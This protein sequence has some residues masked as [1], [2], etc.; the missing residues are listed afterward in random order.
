M[1]RFVQ[2]TH[3]VFCS[4]RAIQSCLQAGEGGMGQLLPVVAAALQGLPDQQ[5]SS[6]PHHQLLA[7]VQQ[8]LSELEPAQLQQH[9]QQLLLQAQHQWQD[10]QRVR[11]QDLQGGFP[12][13]PWQG[14]MQ[15]ADAVVD[16]GAVGAVSPQGPTAVLSHL[17][18]APL[19]VR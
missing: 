8:G 11:Q 13:L 9:I 18:T 4:N 14:E 12:V 2:L 5:H 15:Q 16:A 1:L 10:V 19:S 6:S 17:L 3:A 7:S